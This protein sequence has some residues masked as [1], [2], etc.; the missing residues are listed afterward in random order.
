MS[1]LLLKYQQLTELEKPE[2]VIDFFFNQI[3]IVPSFQ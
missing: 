2:V 3:M 1:V